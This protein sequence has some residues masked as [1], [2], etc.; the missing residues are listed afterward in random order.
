MRSGKLRMLLHLMYTIAGRQWCWAKQ[1]TIKPIVITIIIRIKSM[2]RQY[3]TLQKVL[4]L[5]LLNSIAFSSSYAQEIQ[6]NEETSN[7]VSTESIIKQEINTTVDDKQEVTKSIYLYAKPNVDSQK[8]ARAINVDQIRVLET[9]A[10]WLKVETNKLMKLWV[11]KKFVSVLGNLA[12]IERQKTP[13]YLTK[14]NS[15]SHASNQITQL[16]KG[17]MFLIGSRDD[18]WYQITPNSPVIL[19]ASR[20]RVPN[21]FR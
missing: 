15:G 21:R 13:A 16:P 10:N 12:R 14:N 3:T 6:T 19:W 2:K 9:T 20:G 4:Y 11:E 1:V 7:T 8:T 17:K 18:N 5:A